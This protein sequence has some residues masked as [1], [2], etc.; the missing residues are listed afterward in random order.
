MMSAEYTNRQLREG[1]T[2]YAGYCEIEEAVK[3]LPELGYTH[4]IYGWSATVYACGRF[5]L[6]TGYR[7][8][9]AWRLTPEECDR[10]NRAAHNAYASHDTEMVAMAERIGLQ[11]EALAVM[12]ELQAIRRDRRK[13]V[14]K[15]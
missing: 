6:V 14:E 8:A 4:G 15:S 7:P 12:A 5:A 2:Y 11:P 13:A 3:W 10:L 1:M 9:G